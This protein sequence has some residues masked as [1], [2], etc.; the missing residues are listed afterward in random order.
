[1]VKYN[2]RNL[3][4]EQLFRPCRVNQV[5]NENSKLNALN[6]DKKYHKRVQTF[7]TSWGQRVSPDQQEA[8]DMLEVSKRQHRCMLCNRAFFNRQVMVKH[9]HNKLAGL[10][11]ICKHDGRCTQIFRTEA[12]KSEH[13]LEVTNKK[14]KVIKCDFCCLMYFERDHAKHFKMHHKNENLIR[15]SHRPCAT[16]FRSEVEKQN[17]VAL[18]HESTK[19][20]KCILQFVF[21]C[22]Y[23]FAT[24]CDYT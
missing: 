11:I 10:F 14:S 22:N 6:D 12:E 8:K 4:I 16:R 3:F 5:F 19:K 13:I 2:K 18:V 17:H 7:K 21:S 20:D 1:M 9:M 15:C 23:D 24:L